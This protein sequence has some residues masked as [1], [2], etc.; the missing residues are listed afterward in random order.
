MAHDFGRGIQRRQNVDEA[1]K[2]RLEHRVL[3][4]P[5]HDARIGALLR[6]DAGRRMGLHQPEQALAFCAD[7]GFDCGIDGKER[8]VGRHDLRWAG[9]V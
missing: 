2:L 1:K 8:D 7:R 3:H 5:F 6:Q 9:F 4:G